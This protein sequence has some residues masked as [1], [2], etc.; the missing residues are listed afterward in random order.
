M[1]SAGRAYLLR[2][3]LD[4][5]GQI[6]DA[7]LSSH[8]EQATVRRFWPCEA[9]QLGTIEKRGSQLAFCCEDARAA[10]VTSL[11]DSCSLNLGSEVVIEEPCGSRLPFRVA[12]VRK[13][14]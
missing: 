12:S 2:L 8:P 5:Q 3:P 14:A 7:A 13:L 4:E 11:L 9:D 6:D 1:G 10:V